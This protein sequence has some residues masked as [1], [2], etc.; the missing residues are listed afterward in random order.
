MDDS[1]FSVG[2][3]SKEALTERLSQVYKEISS[4]MSSNMLI[5]ND[6]KMHLIVFTS[7]ADS[8]KRENVYIE[9]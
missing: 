3:E 6:D 2:C 1:S 5:L 7:K 9:A 8:D 4:Y